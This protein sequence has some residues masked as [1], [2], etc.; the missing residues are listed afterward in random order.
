LF[1]RWKALA[2]FD[3]VFR[4][5]Q[6]RYVFEYRRLR[7]AGDL[8]T[9]YIKPADGFQLPAIMKWM[10]QVFA[11]KFNKTDGR[12]GHI[13]GDRYWSRIV[14]GEPPEDEAEAETKERAGARPC[15]GRNAENPHFLALF[16]CSTPRPPG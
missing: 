13:W 14:E 10:K 6:K 15:P 7:L 2:V 12:S 5:T 11:V 9:F 1:R 8:L 16:S 3:W 4:E